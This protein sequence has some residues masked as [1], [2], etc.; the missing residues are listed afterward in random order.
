MLR[1]WSNWTFDVYVCHSPVPD[2]GYILQLQ[3]S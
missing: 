3:A 1:R 2:P